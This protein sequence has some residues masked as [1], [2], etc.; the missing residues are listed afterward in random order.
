MGIR[1]VK[2]LELRNLVV[3]IEQ[4]KFTPE[5][6]ECQMAYL[7]QI[8]PS[9][10]QVLFL[11]HDNMASLFLMEN[12]AESICLTTSPELAKQMQGLGMAVLGFQIEKDEMLQASYVVLG[13][14]QVTYDDFLRVFQRFHGIPWHILETKRCQIREFGMDDLD[15]L[16]ALY[17]QPHVTDFIEPLYAY[18]QEREYEQNYIERIYGFYGFGMWLVFEKETGR[19]IGRAGLEYREPCEE[20]EVELGYLIAPSHWQKGY[21]TE[22][23][24]AILTYAKEEL[25]ME[26]IVSHVHLKNDASRHLLEKLGFLGEQKEDEWIYS[27]DL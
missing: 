12:M 17:E 26:R 8:M 14:E 10:E 23:C 25:S 2:A 4:E 13:L 24:Q 22:V 11:K 21:A 19:L 5:N 16:Y 1:E 7:G 3:Y 9:F 6:Y 15:A 20:G 18:A 27:Y